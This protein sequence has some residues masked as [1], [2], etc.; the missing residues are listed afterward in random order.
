MNAMVAGCIDR[1]GQLRR[2]AIGMRTRAG[3]NPG[4]I[5]RAVIAGRPAHTSRHQPAWPGCTSDISR[6]NDAVAWPTG[7]FGALTRH[8]TE[9]VAGPGY[10]EGY[11]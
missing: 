6:M 9:H 7:R 5:L 10:R 1:R 3:G 4:H 2:P 8:R 11:A